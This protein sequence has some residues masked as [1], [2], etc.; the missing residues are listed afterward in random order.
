MAKTFKGSIEDD[1]K[2]RVR[3]YAAMHEGVVKAQKALEPVIRSQPVPANGTEKL[4]PM[5][6]GAARLDTARSKLA[7]AKFTGEKRYAEEG[8][9]DIALAKKHFAKVAR[10]AAVVSEKDQAIDDVE[11]LYL[12]THGDPQLGIRVHPISDGPIR[13]HKTVWMRR[14]ESGRV[15]LVKRRKWWR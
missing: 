11:Q 14:A 1:V 4:G 6:M 5:Q 7:M 10:K 3:A 9:N 8:L 12:K 2:E 15:S 13:P